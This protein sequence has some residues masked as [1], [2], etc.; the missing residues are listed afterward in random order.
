MLNIHCKILHFDEKRRGIT[1]CVC[2]C[3][4]CKEQY[5]NMIRS[6]FFINQ[7]LISALLLF[8]AGVL[9]VNAQKGKQQG[10]KT[11]ATPASKK[12]VVKTTGLTPE[13]L[14]QAYHFDE[15]AKVIQRVIGA[16]K[17]N[18]AAAAR[19]Q[20]E[21]TRANLGAEMLRGTER[22]TFVD[23]MVVSRA[24]FFKSIRLS[25]ESGSFVNL[26]TM[27]I[28]ANSANNI[29]PAT[30]GYIN[31][32]GDRLIFAADSAGSACKQL[33]YSYK[34]GNTWSEAH[35]LPGLEDDD[36]DYANPFMMPDG[37]T[38]YY[39]AQSDES[40]G[41]YDLFLTRYD[42][43]TNQYLKAENIGMPF[44]SPANDY[45]LAIDEK[46]N[47][48]WLVSDRYQDEAHVCVY[49]FIPNTTREVYEMD[50]TNRKH[51]L[52]VAQLHAIAETQDDATVVKEALARLNGVQNTTSA[53]QGSQQQLYVINDNTVY[54]A[55]SQFHSEA[56][57]RIAQQSD[58]LRAEIDNLLAKRDELQQAVAWGDRSKATLN[59]LKQINAYLPQQQQQ[60]KTMLKNMRQKESK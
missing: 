13:Q 52:H 58:V 25:A 33:Y 21:L 44:N 1:F 29:K 14:I 15:A 50:D 32:I 12:A 23:S 55:L 18:V 42:A 11:V 31:Q 53:A 26:H 39:A 46:N 59:K 47:L 38:L 16:A 60:L 41:G 30:I 20:G 37:T 35:L 6:T 24:D 2:K 40:L 19:L 34:M 27:G 45:L 5:L 43:N 49:V 36:T 8:C 17:G 3:F 9:S 4:T 22:V 10:K 54:T 7:W 56:A 48:G 51:V 28:A 57:R